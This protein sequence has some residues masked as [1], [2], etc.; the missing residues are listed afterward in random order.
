MDHWDR[1]AIE[2][3]GLGFFEFS[4]HG[5]GRFRFIA[6]E[7]WMDCRPVETA[8]GPGVEFTWDGSDECD[9]AS[10][11]GIATLQADGSL[12]GHIYVHLGD[13]SAFRAEREGTSER[14]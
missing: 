2:L 6:V 7:G 1:D 3:L 12:H 9:H 5:T 10:G 14:D 4:S 13:D 11:R 8:S